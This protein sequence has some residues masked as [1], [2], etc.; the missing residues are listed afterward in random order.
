MTWRLVSTVRGAAK[1]P[2]PLP[3]RVSIETMAGMERLTT[4][5]KRGVALA[6]AVG[7]GMGIG[8]SE[9]AGLAGAS[10]GYGASGTLGSGARDALE[11]SNASAV[12]AEVPVSADGPGRTGM[13]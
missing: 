6:L 1:N 2:L 4:S 12:D 5:S 3:S 10:M 9:K 13:T 8:I 11:E 7:V